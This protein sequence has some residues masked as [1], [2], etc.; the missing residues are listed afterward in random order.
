MV[1]LLIYGHN[2]PA[3][4]NTRLVVIHLSSCHL[5]E[6][7]SF[8]ARLIVAFALADWK[9]ASCSAARSSVSTTVPGM[10]CDLDDR[11]HVR[12]GADREML[13]VINRITISRSLYVALPAVINADLLKHKRR[14]KFAAGPETATAA[15]RHADSR[16]KFQLRFKN[17][18]QTY[19]LNGQNGANSARAY[20]E[21]VRLKHSALPQ[22]RTCV[23]GRGLGATLS[24]AISCTVSAWTLDLS[25]SEQGGSQTSSSSNIIRRAAHCMHLHYRWLMLV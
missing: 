21:D 7:L 13:H 2:V 1:L 14:S 19:Y 24:A 8:F 3:V 12:C 23:F 16:Q 9:I 25:C 4:L 18:A 10:H 20:P 15:C 17:E 11:Y 22:P 5:S 6:I